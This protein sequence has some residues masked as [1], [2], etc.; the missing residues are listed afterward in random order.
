MTRTQV[1]VNMVSEAERKDCL[2]RMED[3]SQL[4]LP[5]PNQAAMPNL[6]KNSNIYQARIG[7]TVSSQDN[8]FKKEDDTGTP[9]LSGP[10]ES[11]LGFP[12]SSKRGAAEGLDNASKKETTSA[13]AAAAS[14]GK[15]SRDFS[16]A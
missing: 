15:P 9:S 12:L 6:H 10:G 7:D 14:I 8:A 5:N 11:D 4:D 2:A 1:G 3:T 16:L 13:D